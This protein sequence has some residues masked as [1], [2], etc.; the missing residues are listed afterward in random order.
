[1]DETYKKHLFNFCASHLKTSGK[2]HVWKPDPRQSDL[3]CAELIIL[4]CPQ[5]SIGWI[6]IEKVFFYTSA[7]EDGYQLQMKIKWVT[8]FLFLQKRKKS[9]NCLPKKLEE[10]WSTK[11]LRI[12]MGENW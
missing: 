8:N 2:V 6:T 10:S 12:G 5:M 4:D 7:T 1:M 3:Y 11:G 9:K